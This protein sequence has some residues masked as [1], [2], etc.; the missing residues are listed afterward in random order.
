MFELM[1]PALVASLVLVGLHAYLGI[2]I[3][4]RGVIF[5]DLALAQVAALGWAAAGLGLGQVVGGVLGLSD[6]TA[7]YFVG[8]AAT[9]IAAALFS[10][11]RMKHPYVPQEAIIG[12]V[13]VVATAGTI[14]LAAQAP[15]GSE[16]VE[17]LLTGGLLWVTWPEIWKT[18]IAYA[19]IGIAHWF[20]RERF[21][22]ISLRPQDAAAHGWAVRWWDFVFYSLFGVMVTLSVAIA[23]VLLVFTFLVI[24]AVIAFLFTSR[25]SQLL[26]IAW[27]T[28]VAATVAGLYTSYVTDMPTGPV[29][30]CAFAVALVLAFA[31]RR[32][33][34]G[35]TPAARAGETW[36]QP[37]SLQ[38]EPGGT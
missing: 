7:G 25:T 15:R 23:G 2:H 24:P 26:A 33:L 36:E 17:Q 14:L 29:V 34:R 12:I 13:F 4:A 32:L 10:A 30:V 9:L 16:H 37:T 31:L 1:L 35:R 19:V 18:A 8:L 38:G 22:T 3:I 6:A 11:S 20:L 5:V 21:L 27:A 28:G